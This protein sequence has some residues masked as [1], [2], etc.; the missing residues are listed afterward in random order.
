MFNNPAKQTITWQATRWWTRKIPDRSGVKWKQWV[1]S[2]SSQTSLLVLVDSTS[3]R[4]V[5]FKIVTVIIAN[6]LNRMM[7][8]PYYGLVYLFNMVCRENMP[9]LS[10]DEGWYRVSCPVGFHYLDACSRKA[11][12][13]RYGKDRCTCTRFDVKHIQLQHLVLRHVTT[14]SSWW[15]HASSSR[16]YPVIRHQ[17][18]TC[19]HHVT[20]STAGTPST[21]QR[22]QH[23]S[24]HTHKPH[25]F[26]PLRL[27]HCRVHRYY[28][29]TH[30]IHSILSIHSRQTL[31]PFGLFFPFS[32]IPETGPNIDTNSFWHLN[33]SC[34]C[35]ST[36]NHDGS[37]Q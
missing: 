22:H 35:S 11:N 29:H 17:C 36:G 28:K 31:V 9:F 10:F 7:K 20:T 15:C 37:N 19:H 26:V 3:T 2:M 6:T 1:C 27:L 34:F 8:P 33:P 23:S 24:T 21:Q 16:Q 12:I 18:S 4:L 5:A 25:S 14:R 32:Q 13:E 30:S